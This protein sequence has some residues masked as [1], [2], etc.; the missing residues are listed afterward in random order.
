MSKI[1]QGD[2]P[3]VHSRH[4]MR[5]SVTAFPSLLSL[6]AITPKSNPGNKY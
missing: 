5:P 2:A 1:L 3:V 4:P 6:T